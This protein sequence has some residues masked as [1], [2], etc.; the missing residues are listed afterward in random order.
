M[1]KIRLLIFILIIASC[2]QNVEETTTQGTFES[3]KELKEIYEADQADR[4]TADIDW[5]IVSK[6]DKE[7]QKRVHKLLKSNLVRTSDDYANAAMIFQH[8]GD[9]KA[10][11]MT[12]KLMKKAIEL[13]P[14]RDKWLLAAAIDRDLMW[15]EKPQIYGTQYTK[16]SMDAPWELYKLDSTKVTDEERKEY[17]V[18][19]LAQQ[20]QK[21]KMMNKKK[22]YDFLDSGKTIDDIIEFVKHSDLKNSE[23]NLSESGINTFGYQ[24]MAEERN[25]DAL[26]IFKLNT[27]LYPGDYNAYD[28]YGECLV[29]MGRT[30]EG[31][32]AYKKSLQLNPDNDNAEKVLKEIEE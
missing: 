28:S 6:R 8:G 19:T 1:K 2:K 14:N 27:T 18:E 23:Y 3:N 15:R 21:L 12:I 10:F 17:G 13:D 30:G 32:T 31:I 7:R 22:L 16:K 4:Q 29:K 9:S 11:K 26:K 5:S 24:L 25:E 20:R